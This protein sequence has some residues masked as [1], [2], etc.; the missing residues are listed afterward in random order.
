MTQRGHGA[1]RPVLVWLVALLLSGCSSDR[2]SA[3]HEYGQILGQAFRSTFSRTDVP[4]TSV[5]AI[6]YASMGYRINNGDQAVL[7]LATDNGGDQIWTSSKHIVIQTNAGRIT[8]TVGLPHDLGGTTPQRG[9][10]L[11]PIAAALKAPFQSAR[12]EDFPELG[13]YG[14]T[15]SCSAA[16]RRSER[17]TILEQSITTMRVDEVCQTGTLNR[18]FV[19]SYWLDTNTGFAWR[20]LQHVSPEG[21]TVET[22]IFRPPG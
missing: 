11:T 9:Q 15:I 3:Y 2:N 18:R 20:S 13:A 10:V 21:E 19:D 7:V 12:Q 17:I 5:A 4:R 22:E 1:S 6:P 16:A 14:V 8:R